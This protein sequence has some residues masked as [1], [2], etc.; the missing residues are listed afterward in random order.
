MCLGGVLVI[1]LMSCG[2]G[3]ETPVAMQSEGAAGIQERVPMAPQAPDAGLPFVKEVGYYH[4]HK[5]TKPLTDT[6]SAGE[7]DLCEGRVL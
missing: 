5:W 7:N 1:M 3:M 6:V 4:D 2:E